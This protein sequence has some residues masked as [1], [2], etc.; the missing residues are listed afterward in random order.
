MPTLQ[1]TGG[2]TF[3]GADS[4]LDQPADHVRRYHVALALETSSG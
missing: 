1:L 2:R 3:H 4:L